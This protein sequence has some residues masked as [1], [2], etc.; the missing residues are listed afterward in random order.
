MLENYYAPP[1]H[2]TGDEVDFPEAEA[3]HLRV[4]RTSEGD[5]VRVV[6]GLGA[7]HDV[8][9]VKIGR[10]ECRGRILRTRR[11]IAEPVAEITAVQAVLKGERFDWFVEKATE[12]G[13]RRIIPLSSE[14]EQAAAGPQRRERWERIAVAA[15]KQSGRS[16][17]PEI[18]EPAPIHKVLA[19]GAHCQYRFMAHPSNESRVPRIVQDMSSR[20]I[21]CM[22]LTGPES[23]F[24]DREAA[25]AA[26]MGFELVTLGPRRLRSETAGIVLCTLL[27]WQFGEME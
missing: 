19:L 24:T 3:H 17:L 6:D 9:I 20:S 8:E 13:V 7:A 1:S 25:D 27:L 21:K 4:L 14:R 22:V 23:G 2:F 10:L 26:D 16:I 15:M 5:I 12:I 11:R 18:A